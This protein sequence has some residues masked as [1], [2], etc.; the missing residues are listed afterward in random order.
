[1]GD[2]AWYRRD[3]FG[4]PLKALRLHATALGSSGSGKTE[5]LL[6]AAYGA[7]KVYR[8]QVVY[9]DVKGETKREDEQGQDSAARFVATMRAAGAQNVLVFPSLSYYGWHGTPAEMKNRLLSVI[10]FSESAFYG[11]VAANALDLALSAPTTPRTS[12]HFLANLRIDRLKDI[13]ASNRLHYQRVLALDKHLLAQVEMRYQVFFSAMNGQLDGTLDYANADAAYLRVRGF[14]LHAEAPR[15]GR[16]LV[17]D[18]IHYIAE[19]RRP[20]IQTLFIIDEFNAL[21]MREETSIL[22][23]QVRSFGGNLI[24]SAQGYAGLGP[25]EYAERILD[26][27]STYILHTCSDPGPVSRRAGKRLFIDTSWSEDEEGRQHRH[28]RPRYDWRVPET[29]VMQQEEGQAFWIHHGRSQHV[30]TVQVPITPEQVRE[31]WQEIHRQE[32]MQRTLLEIEARRRQEQQAQKK[33]NAGAGNTNKDQNASPVGKASTK[34]SPRQGTPKNRKGLDSES[35]KA[36]QQ[37]APVP[38]LAV[39]PQPQPPSAPGLDDD[40]PDEL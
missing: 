19:R 9:L 21:R 3:T 13:Y 18:F 16:F 7:H 2:L 40:E 34:S 10:D 32:E 26:A 25:H 17:S 22:F 27:C 5:T 33:P 15:L 30:M 37:P 8:Q 31:G 23:E 29:A 14:T 11:D 12:A 36:K 6:R 38:S 20:G 39:P 1:V 24:I 28:I 4:F 35:P